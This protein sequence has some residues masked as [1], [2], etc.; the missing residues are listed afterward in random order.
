MELRTGRKVVILPQGLKPCL[1]RDQ[2]TG[3]EMTY[4][5]YQAAHSLVANRSNPP[6]AATRGT[7]QAATV[8]AHLSE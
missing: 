3:Q 2:Q 6:G 7:V 4:G 1:I 5:L 8:E